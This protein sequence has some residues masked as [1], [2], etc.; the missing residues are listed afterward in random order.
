MVEKWL[1]QVEQ[2]MLASLREV[3]GLGIEA[4]VKMESHSVSQAAV[5]WHDLGSLQPLPPGFKQFSCLS[6][7]SSCDYRHP[8]P[9]PANLCIFS[10]DGVSPYWLGWSQTPDLSDPP[11]LASESAEITGDFLKKSNDQIAQIVQ[12]V[13]GKLSSGARLTLGALTVIDVHARDVVAK[14]SEDRVSD[15]NDFQWIS[16]LRYYWVDKD[17]QVQIITTEALYGY[18]YLGNS[19][20]LVI[21]PLTDRCYRTLMGALKLNLGGA[22]EGPAGTGKTET[23]KDLAKALA[24]QCVVFNCS[25]GLDYKAM[26]KFFKGLAQAGAWACFDEF[27]RIEAPV[28][29]ATPKAEAGEWIDPGRRSLQLAEIPPLHSSLRVEVLSVVAQQILSI[30][31]AIIRKLKTFIFEGTELSL[32]PTCAVFI[33]M[34]PGYAGRAELP[35]NLKALFRTVAMMV[36]D[37]SLIGEISLHSMGFLDSRRLECSVAILAHC[38]LCLPGSSNSPVSAF[39]R[40]GFHHVGQAGLELLTSGDPPASVSQSAGITGRQ[41]LTLSLRLESSGAITAHCSLELLGSSGP[42]TLSL[43][44]SWDDRCHAT[45]A[46]PF[47]NFSI[48]TEPCYIAQ[49]GLKLLASSNPPAS[50]SQSAGITG[51]SHYTW[52]KTY[53][54]IYHTCYTY[55]LAQKIVAT[56]RLCSEQLSSQHHYDYGM[57]AVK[58]VLTAAGNL[59]LKYPEENE[60]VLLLRALLDVNLAKFLAQ[61]VPLFQSFVL[62][63]KLECSGMILSHCNLCLLGSSDSPAS[64]SQTE[65]CFVTQTGVQWCNLGSL[66]PLPP[67]FQQ[68]SCLSLL[69]SWDCRHLPPCLANFCI[70]SKDGVPP[71]WPGWSQTSDLSTI[72]IIISLSHNSLPPLPR[73]E[74]SDV[75]SAHCKLHLPG[76][77]M[78]FHYVGQAG[79]KLLTSKDPPTFASQ[80]A[81]IT[82]VN[83][84][85]RPSSLISD[86]QT[87]RSIFIYEMMLLR[88]GFMIVGDP[89][90]GKTSA[91][92]V[93]AAALGDL[94]ADR[95]LL[96]R[97]AGMQWLDLSS[98]Q[99]LTPWFKRFSCLSLPRIIQWC[100]LSSM[101]P[102]PPEFKRSSYLRLPSSWDNKHAPPCSPKFYIFC[103]DGV[104][105]CCGGWSLTPELKQSSGLR[106]QK[107]S[108]TLPPRLWNAAAWSQLTATSTSWVQ[109]ILLLQ[110]L[111][112]WDYRHAPPHP[113]N[114]C[115]FSFIVLAWLVPNSWPQMIHPPQPPKVLRLEACTTAPG[116][117]FITGVETSCPANQMEEFAV[118]Y[119]IINPKAI[120]MGQLYGCFDQVSHEWTDGVLAN[121]FREQASSPSDDRKWI[122]FDGPVDAVWIENMNTVLD[123]NKKSL[124]LLSRLES[125]GA[126]S[127]H[128]NLCLLSSSDSSASAFPDVC[129]Q[130]GFHHVGQADLKFLTSSDL[131]FS[132]SQSA[133]LGSQLCLMSGEIIQMNSKMSLIFEPADLEQASPATVSR[134]LRNENCLNLGGGGCSE[135]RWHCCTPAWAAQRDAVFKQINILGTY[136]NAIKLHKKERN[137]GADERKIQG[138][139]GM[140]YMEPHQLGWKPLKDSYMDTLPSSLTE[141]HKELLKSQSVTEAGV[142]W[143]DLGS[144]K[145]PPLRF[146]RDGFHHV[147][148]A[149]LELL[150]SSDPPASASQ[151]PGITGMSHSTQPTLTI[152]SAPTSFWTPLNYNK[153]GCLVLPLLC[154]LEYSD[155]IIAHC[156]LKLLGSSD[157]PASVFCIAGTTGA[158]RHTQL[159]FFSS[160]RDRVSLCHPGW[161]QTPGLKQSLALSLRLEC[162]DEIRA[163]E[164]EEMEL[165]EGL[166]SQQIFLW[167]QGLFLFS[168]V[169]T[170]AG[171]INADSRKKFDVFFR[172]L[173]LGMNGDHPRPKSVRLTKNN[174][175]PER[176]FCSFCPGCSVMAQSQLTETSASQR[177]DFAMLLSLFSNSQT[178]S[179][180]VSPRLECSS[181]ISAH[182]NLHLLGSSDSPASASQVDG[183]TGT[184]HHTQLIFVFLVEM[185]F[186]H[187]GQA[188]LKLLTSSDP[189]ALVSQ[190]AGIA[191]VSHHAHPELGFLTRKPKYQDYI[192]TF[193]RAGTTFSLSCLLPRLEFWNPMSAHCNLCLLGLSDP[194]PLASQVAGT[195]GTCHYAWHIFLGFLVETEF[196]HVVQAGLEPLTSA[197]MDQSLPQLFIYF[198]LLIDLFEMESHSVTQAGVQWLDLSSLQPLPPRFKQ[199]YSLSLWSSWNYRS[200]PPRPANFCIFSRD[201]VSPCWPGWSQT[202]G[203]RLSVHFSLPKCWD[204]KHEPPCLTTTTFY[205]ITVQ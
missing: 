159:I 21:T 32:N 86:A 164:E 200:T 166:S 83:Y 192:K 113:A 100:D 150:T 71:R 168:L 145:P 89:M 135:P 8:P 186:H 19:S 165:L 79:L 2:M 142:Q 3:I 30:Q 98:L 138:G 14:L 148:Q 97:Q 115:I 158:H 64:A 101:Q 41:S 68:F 43:L 27:N 162:S 152:S 130:M 95:V 61:D 153:T 109:A 20:R 131:P 91:Y 147:G 4:Y 120:T 188:V 49:A 125:S 54:F 24:K 15:L 163:A 114:F 169:W 189:P 122:I 94:Y 116:K 137:Q 107:Q 144:L 182:C 48:E 99:L 92:K 58:S 93:L 173:I 12:L 25:D 9:R 66:Q 170:V 78:G 5:Q 102:L 184:C 121:T 105:L 17:V 104:L 140:I 180:A 80:S 201:G 1:Q 108:L 141:E 194:P 85:A 34:N 160:Y 55:I 63:P 112:S 52:P 139:C 57:R 76:S 199:F 123:D 56:Y 198:Y 196:Y 16:Q 10:R 134:R 126:I 155:A 77:N 28:I 202:P 53:D 13:R 178:Q 72:G 96:C 151:S 37:Y 40:Q 7:P 136:T 175:F 90:G 157:S 110:P 18:E 128:C 75:I 74:C 117:A 39:R 111:S 197:A 205:N 133:V 46:S 6:F 118:E 50:A 156:S 84:Q 149:G 119:K 124:P 29:T 38:N 171:T 44:S 82:G 51:M 69:G 33:T 195:T 172:N 22:P 191:G 62:L 70:F 190:S 26:G 127:T 35:D 187:V 167:L 143:Q 204:Y 45:M 65:S 193:S 185:E 31:Q 67:R 132:A 42:P 129:Q 60:S 23:T 179:L 73:L 59:K 181:M 88:H 161:S 87:T 47:K 174:I 176:E 177:Q 154:T 106:L 103:R 36:P 203:L 11:A 146:N 81:G 183:I